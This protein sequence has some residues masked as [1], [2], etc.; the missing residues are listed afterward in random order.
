MSEHPLDPE[1]LRATQRKVERKR[2][3]SRKSLSTFHKCG[4]TGEDR[5][6]NTISSYDNNKMRTVTNR[7]E[8]IHG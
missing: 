2:I 3:A 6:T 7:D 8:V 4:V 5:V 1:W